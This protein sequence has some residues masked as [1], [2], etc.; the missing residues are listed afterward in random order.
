MDRQRRTD[1]LP[2]HIPLYHSGAW[3]KLYRLQNIFRWNARHCHFISNVVMKQ[4]CAQM[5]NQHEQLLEK[6]AVFTNF[7]DGNKC[8]IYNTTL[9]MAKPIKKVMLNFSY[10]LIL[11][12]VVPVIH[13]VKIHHF[14]LKEESALTEMTLLCQPWQKACESQITN[15]CLSDYSKNA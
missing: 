6:E 14:P 9:K 13:R 3:L 10:I 7:T 11:C 4:K 12:W 5:L 15:R 8:Q 2:K 1:T